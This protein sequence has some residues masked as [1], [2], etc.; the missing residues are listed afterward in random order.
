MTDSKPSVR[1]RAAPRGNAKPPPRPGAAS[2]STSAGQRRPTATSATGEA[3]R[4][5]NVASGRHANAFRQRASLRLLC[6][7]ED[8][9]TT[10]SPRN[11]G[12]TGALCVFS[13]LKS[14]VSEKSKCSPT[15][16][17]VLPL[18]SSCVVVCAEAG[19][20]ADEAVSMTLEEAMD[21]LELVEI[22]VGDG[23]TLDWR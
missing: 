17:F 3:T 20:G 6:F 1:A 19:D 14:R 9:L 16:F 4:C 11:L 22:E 7:I 23:A 8:L 10:S 13:W 2:T 21:R 12:T 18:S 15:P 5:G